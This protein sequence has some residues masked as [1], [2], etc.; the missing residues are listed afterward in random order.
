V[1]FREFQLDVFMCLFLVCFVTQ[2]AYYRTRPHS[3]KHLARANNKDVITSDEIVAARPIERQ[4]GRDIE[5]EQQI[6][7]L[8]NEKFSLPASERAKLIA[9]GP[10]PYSR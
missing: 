9:S 4:S 5:D 10:E 8:Y 3:K 1:G 2:I 7:T 6:R